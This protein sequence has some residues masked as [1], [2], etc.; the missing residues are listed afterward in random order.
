MNEKI[1][2]IQNKLS[3]LKALDK[4]YRIFGADTHKYI[5]NDTLSE[6]EIIEFEKNFNIKLPEGY[7][8]FIQFIGNGGAG[9]FYGL[10]SLT[11]ALHQNL[12]APD[13]DQLNDISK[14]F[15]YTDVWNPINELSAVYDKLNKAQEDGNADNETAAWN[16]REKL[17]S[18]E[19]NNYG[20]LNLCNYGC[21]VAIFMV[22]NGAEYGNIWMD[23]RINDDGIYPFNEFGNCERID[24][25][26][27]YEAWLDESIDEIRKKQSMK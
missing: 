21:G 11:S 13:D 4:N 19:K 20:R 1:N 5:L 3:E 27:F 16:E 12:D 6:A 14:P 22:V 17:I 8:D 25:L 24:F 10:Q 26:N 7:S 15:P 23:A 2:T 18:D 9:P